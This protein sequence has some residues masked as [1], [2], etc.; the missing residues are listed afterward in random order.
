MSRSKTETR[1]LILLAIV[2][3]AFEVIAFVVPFT[4]GTVFWLGYSFTMIAFGACFVA[5]RC[6]FRGASPRCRFY[7]LP[8]AFVLRA[9]LIVQLAVG[10]LCMM[11]SA[12]P[13]WVA[14][15]AGLLPLAWFSFGAVALDL[16][17]GRSA[18]IDAATGEKVQ[19]TRR[20]QHEAERLAA[21]AK[22]ED[23]RRSL[24]E[25]AEAARYSDPMSSYE[26]ANLETAITDTLAQADERLQ[27]GDEPGALVL[28]EKAKAQLTERNAQCRMLK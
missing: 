10:L 13:V 26:L 8:L 18:D 9:Y 4:R 6:A 24:R 25:L 3:A 22:D 17:A 15:V 5:A 16:T 1:F 27:A 7:G 28:C 20:L 19:Y 2:L 23:L 11:L 14:V 12:L 21:A